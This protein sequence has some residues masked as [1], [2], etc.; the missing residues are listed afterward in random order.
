MIKILDAF[1][2][3]GISSLAEKLRIKNSVIGVSPTGS[4]KTVILSSV[5]NRFLKRS[6]KTV[7]CFVHKEE[8]LEQIRGTAWGWYG[9]ASQ[10]IDSNTKFIQPDVRFYVIMVET[11]NNRTESLAFL[12]N[13]KNVGLAMFD[14][15]HIGN[16][17][18]ILEHFPESKKLGF[19]ATPV[20]ANKHE[21]LNKYWEDIVII[22]TKEDVLNLNKA[23][24]LR[25]IV[26]AIEWSLPNVKR[27]QL[28]MGK[29]EF[30]EKQ[31]SGV[32]RRPKHIQNTMDA[33]FN[34]IYGMKTII[35]NADV[36]H[37]LDMHNAMR[38]AGINSR[39]LDGKKSGKYGNP[40]YRKETFEWFKETP[41]AVL[42]NIGVATTGFDEPSVEA[43]VTNK[44]TASLPLFEQIRGRGA[45]PFQYKNGSFKKNFTHLDM[46]DN[47]EGG[48]F[49]RYEWNIDWEYKFRNPKIS[50]H[51]FSP[52]KTCPVCHAINNVSARYC[53][54]LIVDFLSDEE[55]SCGYQFPLVS[56]GIKE[57]DE[58]IRE[59][60]LI[61]DGIDVQK[62]VEFFK[63]RNEYFAMYETINQVCNL[64]KQQNKSGYIDSVDIHKVYEI[65]YDKVTQWYKLVGK[66]KFSTFRY[67]LKRK[68]V[69]ALDKIG[70]L[71]LPEEIEEFYGVD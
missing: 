68:V 45:R 15:I 28:K 5:V 25:G 31:M 63:D 7:V 8:I 35:F 32:F 62:N 40:R 36:E 61:S 54:G 70:F 65:C 49:G 21:P 24:P 66:R 58:V 48:G 30:D 39:H 27:E 23:N 1:Q 46:G 55:T 17:V 44:T 14:E 12:D 50:K 4:G 16:F 20:S 33:Y 6:D 11:F 9:I 18:K 43:V 57:H 2:E 3:V 52:I 41:D 29:D 22:A 42:N 34:K 10:R 56:E 71:I 13:F 53:E 47:I 51:G 64:F 59:M 38:E 37:S 19:T 69:D 26:P 67:D 60:K